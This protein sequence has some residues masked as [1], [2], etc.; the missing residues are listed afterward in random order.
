MFPRTTTTAM[1]SMR[2]THIAPFV[3]GFSPRTHKV[4]SELNVTLFYCIVSVLN[5][6][7]K[8][9]TRRQKKKN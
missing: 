7:M 4:K 8:I 5:G 3:M 9:V 2:M 1:I 6:H